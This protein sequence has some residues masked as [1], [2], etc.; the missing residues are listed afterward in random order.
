MPDRPTP[1]RRPKPVG[2]GENASK[3][4]RMAEFESHI[5]RIDEMLATDPGAATVAAL[6]RER[7]MTL[8][9]IESLTVTDGP[10]S[11]TDEVRRKREE[12][13]RAVAKE[14]KR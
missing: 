4:D 12:R 14:A 9:A 5:A 8:N 11:T 6:L 7:R 13:R 2:K 1:N 3:P 10:G